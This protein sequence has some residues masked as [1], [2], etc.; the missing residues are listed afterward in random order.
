MKTNEAITELEFIKENGLI[1]PDEDASAI[2]HA[3]DFMKRGAP[4]GW[5]LVPVEPTLEMLHDGVVADDKRTGCETVKYIYTIM[6]NA[7]PEVND[8]RE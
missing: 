3:I 2:Q 1:H 8:D 6:I 7:A 5:R 4:D